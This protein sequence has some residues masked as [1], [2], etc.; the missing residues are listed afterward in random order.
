M[1][2]D[3]LTYFEDLLE[4]ESLLSSLRALEKDYD[5][6]I[7]DYIDERVFVD[8]EVNL[9]GTGSLSW[10]GRQFICGSKVCTKDIMCFLCALEKSE[11][12]L[13]WFLM[14][15][16]AFFSFDSMAS[17][18]KT[19]TS[20]LFPPRSPAMS[21]LNGSL[22]GTNSKIAHWCFSLHVS[23]NMLPMSFLCILYILCDW[24]WKLWN[25]LGLKLELDSNLG[26]NILMGCRKLAPIFFNISYS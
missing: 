5:N 6:A 24:V 9:F 16:Y 8:E 21:H 18:S 23:L 12:K 22:V 25:H 13:F 11:N 14:V 19:I 2:A 26:P 15:V 1:S 10:W 17:P 3:G 4:G 7:K 20:P